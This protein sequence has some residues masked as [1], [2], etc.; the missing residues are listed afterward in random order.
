MSWTLSGRSTVSVA[1]FLYDPGNHLWKPTLQ[2]FCGCCCKTTTGFR[3]NFFYLDQIWVHYN[4]VII[5]HS[6]PSIDLGGAYQPGERMQI[7]ERRI[8]PLF[9]LFPLKSSVDSDFLSHVEK[10]LLKTTTN[11][12]NLYNE[13]LAGYLNSAGTWAQQPSY[14]ISYYWPFIRLIPV[15][16][17]IP[18]AFPHL[19][20][21]AGPSHP[22][23]LAQRSLVL[24]ACLKFRFLPEAWS[25]WSRWP[26]PILCS[27][28]PWE[29]P[30][31]CLC[32]QP[33]GW[34][35]GTCGLPSSTTLSSWKG[36]SM[37]LWISS[38]TSPVSPSS[39]NSTIVGGICSQTML[40]YKDKHKCQ[41]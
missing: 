15:V 21:S 41:A 22:T 18:G 13:A 20:V 17:E 2:R 14:F 33:G 30:D 37:S 23:P 26:S 11:P 29:P 12:Q 6:A 40:A 16:L 39:K 25:L 5:Y 1:M 3:V 10:Q 38:N 7:R 28:M 24:K 32:L 9:R 34:A 31:H 19:C 27:C 35:G 4:S 36:S 8:F